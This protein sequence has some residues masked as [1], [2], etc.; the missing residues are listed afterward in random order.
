MFHPGIMEEN[1]EN[2][3][4]NPPTAGGCFTLLMAAVAIVLP[5][6][7]LAWL[8]FRYLP[9]FDYIPLMSHE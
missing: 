6:S 1:Y 2:R 8:A 7:V 9:I 3:V 5:L 4:E